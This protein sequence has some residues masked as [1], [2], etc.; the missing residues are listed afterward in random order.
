MP[1]VTTQFGAD[2][3]GQQAQPTT[4][5]AE[6][7]VLSQEAAMPTMSTAPTMP[8]GAAISHPLPPAWPEQPEDV[9]QTD[10]VE[11]QEAET[12]EGEALPLRRREDNATRPLFER[13]HWVDDPNFWDT[14]SFI[15]LTG[16]HP[17]PR[18]KPRT[19]PPPQRFKPIERW[20]SYLVLA[21]VLVAILITVYGVIQIEHYGSNALHQL[22]PKATPTVTYTPVPSPTAKSTPKHK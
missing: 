9:E 6:E 2:A 10:E 16:R 1:D 22:T 14:T 5:R 18:P 13:D 15:A 8:A 7:A 3:W 19:L 17:V 4:Q 11:E 20:Q 21:I 12:P